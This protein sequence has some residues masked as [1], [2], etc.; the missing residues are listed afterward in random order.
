MK[1]L[2]VIDAAALSF[3]LPVEGLRFE[4]MQC[5]FPAVTC[6]AQA[7]FR[8][9]AAPAVHGMIA[10]G[11]YDRRLHRPMFWEQS[12]DLVQGPRIWDAFRAKGGTVGML[13][14]QQS[15]GERADAV[16]SP[17]PIHKHHGGMIQDCYSRPAGLYE[18][19]CRAVGGPFNLMHY[20][21][22]LASAKAGD[23]IAAA[24]VATLADDAAT[25]RLLLTYLP[26]L[27]YDLQR[28]GPDHARSAAARAR[29]AW[30]LSAMV[31]A[32][33]SRDY[34]VVIFGDYAVAPT[35]GGAAWPNRA[36]R[37][38]GLM[39]VRVVR[40]REHADFHAGRAF[41]VVDHEIAHVYVKDPADVPAVRETLE[42]TPGIAEVM[43]RA[44]QARA[45][46]DHANSGELVIVAAGGAWLAYPWWREKSR[47]PDYAAHVDIHN[48]PGYD[49]CELFFG[50]PPMSVS[51]DAGRIRGSHGR[52]GADRQAAWASTI[53]FA[54]RPRSLLDLAASV[55]NWLEE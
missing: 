10:N 21:G 49:P 35:P 7:S 53:P 24:T 41:A 4:K 43:D 50:W 8:T 13:F 34:E 51:Q 33:R 37:E 39:S 12:A 9:A 45:G 29:A 47:A 28:W 1:K 44:A 22:P 52:A 30:Q 27:D 26:T 6:T 3:D 19:L 48:K 38:A 36:L 55:K 15:L 18:R 25:P 46:L 40:G 11:L 31:R 14:W 42:S 54:S 2:L 23:W 17:A 32:A 20:W 16:L 5:V